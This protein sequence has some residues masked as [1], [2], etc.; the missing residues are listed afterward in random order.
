VPRSNDPVAAVRKYGDAFDNG[1]PNRMIRRGVT[2][3]PPLREGVPEDGVEGGLAIFLG[4][5]S[6]VRRFEFGKRLDQRPQLP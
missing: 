5:A 1:D 6:L 4:C 2:C 3:G